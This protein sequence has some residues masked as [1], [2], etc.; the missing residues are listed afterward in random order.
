M[1]VR[2]R[3]RWARTRVIYHH[4]EHVAIHTCLHILILRSLGDCIARMESESGR[5]NRQ[6]RIAQSLYSVAHDLG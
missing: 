4:S 5:T 1:E 3:P 6:Q 2:P